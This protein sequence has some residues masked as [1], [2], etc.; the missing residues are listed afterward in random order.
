MVWRRF[1]RGRNCYAQ[2]SKLAEIVPALRGDIPRGGSGMA[3]AGIRDS[4]IKPWA[5]SSDSHRDPSR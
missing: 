3:I 1:L 5:N 4:V 2:Q